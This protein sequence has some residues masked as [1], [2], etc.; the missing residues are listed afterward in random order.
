VKRFKHR[1]FSLYFERLGFRR[2][3]QMSTAVRQSF[4][5]MK[6]DIEVLGRG[7]MWMSTRRRIV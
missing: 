1:L 3:E 7:S 6:H 4:E 2:N 5:A